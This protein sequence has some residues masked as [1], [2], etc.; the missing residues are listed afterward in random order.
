MKAEGGQGERQKEVGVGVGPG[1]G[2]GG[3]SPALFHVGES[4]IN[5]SKS[6][7]LQ[8]SGAGLW[9]TR[10]PIRHNPRPAM[11]L[12][13]PPHSGSQGIGIQQAVPQACDLSSRCQSARSKQGTADRDDPGMAHEQPWEG[14]GAGGEIPPSS[15]QESQESS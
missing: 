13:P 10:Q 2:S 6:K 4:S 7:R 9:D 8:A 15:P 14:L 5:N 12:S 3:T 11:G 1:G